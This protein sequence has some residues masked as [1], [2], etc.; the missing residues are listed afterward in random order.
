MHYNYLIPS[1]MLLVQKEGFLNCLNDYEFYK[2]NNGGSYNKDASFIRD[3]SD[4]KAYKIAIDQLNIGFDKY[5]TEK[6]VIN[7]YIIDENTVHVKLILSLFYDGVQIYNHK[8]TNCS[9]LI[10]T[11]LNLPP[12][13]RPMQGVGN[14]LLLIYLT[15]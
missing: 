2:Y 7:D 1:I 14:K 13:L 15:N 3:T 6:T 10:L 4:G 5:K 12:N 9:P 8:A 11:I